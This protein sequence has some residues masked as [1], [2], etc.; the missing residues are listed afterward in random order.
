LFLADGT[1][2]WLNAASRI[3]YGK[4]F[5]NGA[6]R[7]VYLDGEAFFDVAH[8]P[9]KPF[10]VHTSS[11][12]IKVLGTSFN[13]RSYAEDNTIETTLVQG[14]VRIEHPDQAG[15]PSGV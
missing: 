2:V 13:V 10:I 4:N 11:I 12:Q 14:K 9:D 7:D 8:D 5:G 6:L 3:S 15:E 1:K